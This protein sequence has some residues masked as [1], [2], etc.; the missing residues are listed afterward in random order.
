L[1]ETSTKSRIPFFWGQLQATRPMNRL[2]RSARGDLC[3]DYALIRDKTSQ[4]LV[5]LATPWGVYR[6]SA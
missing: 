4:L 1:R 6:E 2:L 5:N 3:A